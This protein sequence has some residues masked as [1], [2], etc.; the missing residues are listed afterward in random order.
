MTFRLPDGRILLMF[1][2]DEP[3][4]PHE[5]VETCIVC[6]RVDRITIWSSDAAPRPCPP[7]CY[8]CLDRRRPAGAS[9]RDQMT[10]AR[11]AA[12]AAALRREATC[13][14]M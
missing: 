9:W 11:L 3:E 10:I 6:G 2:H 8:E 14:T 12:L 4:P 7:I 5:V 13:R 1:E